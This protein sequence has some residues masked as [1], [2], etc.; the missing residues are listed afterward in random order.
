[1]GI[2]G[3]LLVLDW[4]WGDKEVWGGEEEEPC[5]G[6]DIKP[7]QDMKSP[8]IHSILNL[9]LFERMSSRPVRLGGGFPDDT[10][11]WVRGVALAIGRGV[12]LSAMA[13]LSCA[14]FFCC[15]VSRGVIVTHLTLL[16]EK[17]SLLFLQGS[18]FSFIHV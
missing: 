9:Y 3:C 10:F 16:R 1:M 4:L 13:L 2:R 18:F 14:F 12:D 6:G 5:I 17:D 7:C 11:G 8:I 15:R